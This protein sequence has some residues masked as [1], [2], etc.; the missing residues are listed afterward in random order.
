MLIAQFVQL[1][2]IAADT[3]IPAEDVQK[4]LLATSDF[5]KGMQDNINLYV[6]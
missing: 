3:T 2:R 6:V 4:Y 1:V 5:R